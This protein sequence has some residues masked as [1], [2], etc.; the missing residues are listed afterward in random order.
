MGGKHEDIAHLWNLGL[1]VDDDN[2]SVE[3]IF[4]LPVKFFYPNIINDGGVWKYS[5]QWNTG[6]DLM[7]TNLHLI[8]TVKNF[9]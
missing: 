6:C 3:E 5:L 4:L 7:M 9:F 2:D 1:N 8:S